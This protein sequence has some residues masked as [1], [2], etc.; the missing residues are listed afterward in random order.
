MPAGIAVILV[1][2]APPALAQ[3]ASEPAQ[4]PPVFKADAATLDRIRN[5]VET[6]PAL[7]LPD[8]LRFYL[9]I[10]G[11]PRRTWQDYMAGAG[12]PFAIT[13]LRPPST[14]PGGDA[15]GGG[16]GIDLLGL[17]RRMNEAR[18]EREA[19]KLREQ[20]SREL[21][22]IEDRELATPETGSPPGAY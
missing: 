20:I 22:T 21:R 1:C 5:A 7:V 17:F 9:E 18:R 16:T 8:A 19:Q 14:W 3:E 13:P 6:P 4:P 2:L 11:S 10:V 12:N 15:L